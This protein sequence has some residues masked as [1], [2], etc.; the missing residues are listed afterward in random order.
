MR[1]GDCRGKG[2][3]EVTMGERDTG[4]GYGEKGYREGTVGKGIQGGDC[5]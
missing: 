2:Y 4:G 3:W 1:G 5:G